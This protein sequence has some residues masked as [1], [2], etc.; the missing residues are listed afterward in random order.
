MPNNSISLDDL[1]FTSFEKECI[2][3]HGSILIGRF[4][5]YCYDWDEL[6]VDETCEEFE[7]CCCEFG[8]EYGFPRA[9]TKQ[10]NRRQ[11]N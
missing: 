1:N 7:A 10:C 3:E 11:E 9:E 6:P 5:H 8:N 4:R 2:R